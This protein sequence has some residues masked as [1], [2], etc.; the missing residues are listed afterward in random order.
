[1]RENFFC[2]IEDNVHIFLAWDLDYMQETSPKSLG[3]QFYSFKAG[4]E[5]N[6]E[7]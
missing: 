5:V 2:Q 6:G 4:A 1:M 7:Y 3:I